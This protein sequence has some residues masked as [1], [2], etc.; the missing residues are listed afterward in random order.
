MT[1]TLQIKAGNYGF[2]VNITVTQ[3]DGKTVVDL[4]GFTITLK[5]WLDDPAVLAL[6]VVIPGV[7]PLANGVA[8]WT[9]TPADAAALKAAAIPTQVTN[10]NGEV[11]LTK[12][13]YVENN[14]D[15]FIVAVV[16]SAG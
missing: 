2:P 7:A 6:S 5:V 10:F 12:A 9:P 11:E 15:T 8:C 16:P 14:I 3:N 4:T 13:S 1:Q